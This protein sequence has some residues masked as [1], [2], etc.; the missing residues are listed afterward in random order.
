VGEYVRMRASVLG[1][2][3]SALAAL[4]CGGVLVVLGVISAVGLEFLMNDTVL[5]PLLALSLGV[6][7]WRLGE[8]Y[9][10]IDRQV[11][12]CWGARGQCSALIGAALWNALVL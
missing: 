9:P 10:G 4:C 8:A 7:F 2:I 3:G 6:A 5:L 11:W 12:W 1:S